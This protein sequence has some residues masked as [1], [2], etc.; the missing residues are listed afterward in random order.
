MGF[1]MNKILVF[2]AVIQ[3]ISCS[4]FSNESDLLI[5]K[6]FSR[7]EDINT[8]KA[9]FEQYNYWSEIQIEKKSIGVII[10][11]EKKML[12]KYSDPEGQLL[13][14]DNRKLTMYDAKSEQAIITNIKDIVSEMKPI[15]I[16]QYY[17]KNAKFSLDKRNNQ[18]L[19]VLDIIN[20]EFIS[21]IEVTLSDDF[22]IEKLKYYDLENNTVLYEFSNI[23]IN[24]KIMEDI[25]DVNLPENT[26][27][28][29]NRR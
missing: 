16:I 15:K 7:Y 18:N 21:K 24:C 23:R 8:F 17:A 20:D 6:M 1:G 2:F 28:I 3:T 27:I 9:D 13:L 22:I 25:F 14:I 10:Y 4:L 26:S 29:D 12:L 11:N 5:K 19:I